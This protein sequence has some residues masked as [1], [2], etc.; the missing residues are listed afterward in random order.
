MVI[1]SSDNPLNFILA[2][3]FRGV[4]RIYLCQDLYLEQGVGAG[5][6]KKGLLSKALGFC[7]MRSFGIA[8]MIIPIGERMAV[9]LKDRL[10]ISPKKITVIM[11]WADAEKILPRDQTNRFSIKH[12]FNGKFVVLH[13]G[14]MGV[15]QDIEIIL[16][17]AAELK[18]NSDIVFLL[19]GEGVQRSKLKKK[20]DELGLNNVRFMHYQKEEDL[21]DLLAS[22]SVSVILYREKLIHSLVPSRL[23]TFMASARP[24]IAAVDRESSVDHIIRDAGCG[25]VIEIGDLAGLKKAV[26]EAYNDREKAAFMGEC[27]RDY[28]KRHFSRNLMTEKYVKTLGEV[29]RVYSMKRGAL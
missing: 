29:A 20:R 25:K 10:K 17:C 9:Y 4:P 27:G 1:F 7:Q 8:N 6:V 15:T 13:S 21:N 28:L 26:L 18:D 11:N 23:F 5:V 22:A 3:M 19:V 12:G 16:K 24:V 2:G 14:R